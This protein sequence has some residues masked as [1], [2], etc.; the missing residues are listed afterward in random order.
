MKMAEQGGS[1]HWQGPAA[2]RMVQ[3]GSLALSATPLP[4]QKF[5]FSRTCGPSS[6]S[7]PFALSS[8]LCYRGRFMPKKGVWNL[9]LVA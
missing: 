5:R 1:G 9:P 8:L 4:V 7:F 3:A 2:Q 6:V